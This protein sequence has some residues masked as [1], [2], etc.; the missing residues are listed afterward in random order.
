MD[1]RYGHKFINADIATAGSI[2]TAVYIAGA[3]RVSIEIATLAVGCITS[4]A[5]VFVFVANSATGTFRKLEDM[6]I[7]SSAS[8][9]QPWEHPSTTGN[10]NVLCRPVVGYNWMK[11]QISNTATATVSINVHTHY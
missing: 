1:G 10:V 2:S 4:T 11:V 9:L 6:G 8:G 3:N 7:Y 5:N